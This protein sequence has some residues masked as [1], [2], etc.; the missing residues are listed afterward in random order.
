MNNNFGDNM[1]KLFLPL[2]LF[3]VIFTAGCKEEKKAVS[4]DVSKV[5]ETITSREMF[6]EIKAKYKGNIV[7]INFFGSWCAPCKAETPDFVDVYTENKHKNFVIVGISVDDTIEKAQGFV[8]Q[9][10]I[11]YPVYMIDKPTQAYYGVSAIPTSMVIDQEGNLV[12][13]FTGI[14]TRDFL[15]QLASYA[16]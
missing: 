5:G 3:T 1:K 7:L 2:L 4:A 9:F 13:I 11:N 8:D 12:D 14:L 15:R 16:Q 10:N 6:E